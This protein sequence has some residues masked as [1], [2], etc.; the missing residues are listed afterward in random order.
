MNPKMWTATA[1]Q[2]NL[3]TI[4]ADGAMTIGPVAGE[5]A[6]SGETGT[7]RMAEPLEIVAAVD[8]F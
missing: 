6:E 7:G 1:T 3:A 5:M 4:V 2:R 8:A